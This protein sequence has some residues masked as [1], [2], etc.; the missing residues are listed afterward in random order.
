MGGHMIIIMP[1]IK[2]K[3]SSRDWNRTRVPHADA[4]SIPPFGHD[5]SSLN[6]GLRLSPVA[7]E[8]A[9]RFNHRKL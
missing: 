3:N 4:Y 2:R 1:I 8:K 5:R 7:R 6:F 9:L